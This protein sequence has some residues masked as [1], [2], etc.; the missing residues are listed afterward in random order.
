MANIRSRHKVKG[1]KM[2]EPIS[3]PRSTIR[4]TQYIVDCGTHT[5]G[6]VVIRALAND[7]QADGQPFFVKTHRN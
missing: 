3:N 5:Q 1:I 2:A 7:L 6:T 4:K